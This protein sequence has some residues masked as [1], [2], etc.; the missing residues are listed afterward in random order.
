M[1]LAAGAVKLMMSFD[2]VFI[3]HLVKE[4][5]GITV[6]CRKLQQKSQDMN[7]WSKS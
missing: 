1:Q 5:M 3:L 6:L 7:G 2:F 4:L